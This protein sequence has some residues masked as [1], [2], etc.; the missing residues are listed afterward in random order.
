M[1][2]DYRPTE[3]VMVY[4]PHQQ[5]PFDTVDQAPPERTWKESPLLWIAVVVVVFMAVPFFANWGARTSA[6][7]KAR[8]A[9]AASAPVAAP[10]EAA[11]ESVTPEGSA[12]A[13]VADRPAPLPARALADPA[14]QMVS[15]C[16]E[17]GRVVYTQTGQCAGS[18]TAVPID[19]SKNVVGPGGAASR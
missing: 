11:T 1:A 5:V 2:D 9:Q 17:N 15:K 7:A 8:H 13:A 12:P 18:V 4:E 10:E 19:T 6:A 14:R 16:V 3:P